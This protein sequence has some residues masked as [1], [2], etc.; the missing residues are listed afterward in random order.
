MC[1]TG[2]CSEKEIYL[3]FR[4]KILTKFTPLLCLK[5]LKKVNVTDTKTETHY[6]Y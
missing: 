5:N 2:A 3:L 4:M 1:D 6:F